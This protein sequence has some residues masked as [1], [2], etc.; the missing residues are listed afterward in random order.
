M[1]R[2]VSKFYCAACGTGCFMFY[3]CYRKCTPLGTGRIFI[4]SR[5]G[6]CLWNDSADFAGYQHGIDSI[7][8]NYLRRNQFSYFCVAV[9]FSRRRI[10]SG[11]TEKIPNVNEKMRDC[12]EAEANRQEN[13]EKIIIEKFHDFYDFL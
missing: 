11:N 2:M 9:H 8:V 4:L 13:R 7:P 12:I 5:S 6:K 10:H 1:E 3:T